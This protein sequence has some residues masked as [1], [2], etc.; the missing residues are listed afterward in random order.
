MH[1]STRDQL[2]NLL[3]NGDPTADGN[4]ALAHLKSCSKCAEEVAS[5]Q[6]TAQ[7]LRALRLAD[8]LE[9]SAGFYARVL[10]RIEERT[11]ISEWGA[12]LYSPFSKRLAYAS[13]SAALILGTY[14]FTAESMEESSQSLEQS[15]QV[16]QLRGSQ[17]E[18]RDA[19]LVNLV[20]FEKSPR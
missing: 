20:S 5:M 16:Q 6:T 2:E 10:Q 15:Q 13:L 14:V 3:G 4:G 19:V 11:Y 18:R 12:F 9:P 17:S 1:G 8:E 7:Q